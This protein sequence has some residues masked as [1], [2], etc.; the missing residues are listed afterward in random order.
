MIERARSILKSVFG[1]ERFLSL[2]EEVIEHVLRRK[3]CLVVMPTG[4]GKS[5]CYQL[6]ALMFEGLTIVVSPL[7]SLMKDQVE[8][9]REL[10]APVALLNSSLPPQDYRRNV[11][12]I[13]AGRAKLLYAAPETLMKTSLQ[14]LLKKVQ[15]ACLA[16]DE[17]HCISEWGPDFR[18]EYRRLAQVR[19]LMPDSVCMALTATATPRVREDI[20]NCL[21]IDS[22]SEFIA[23]FNRENLFIRVAPKDDPIH[24]TVQFLS[25]FPNES[26]IIYCLTRKQVDDLCSALQ[27]R[28]FQ[29]I[30]YHAGLSEAERHRNQERFVRDQVPIIVATIAFGIGID[31]SNVR[32]ILHYDLPRSIE[33]YYQEIGRAGRDGLPAHCL[34]L[35]SYGDIYKIRAFIDKKE[36]ND[37]RIASLQLN[38]MLQLAEAEVCRRVPLLAYFGEKFPHTGCGMCDNCLAGERELTDVTIP[39]QKFLS[40]V[41]RTGET[42]GTAHIINV[43]LGSKAQKI[44]QH[45][46]DRLSTYG[47]GREY[48]HKQWQ[49][50]ARQLIHKELLD[51]DAQFGSLRLTQQAW[52]VLR[53][54]EHVFARVSDHCETGPVTTG[55]AQPRPAEFDRELFEKLRRK[56]RELADEAKVPPYVVFSDKTL[57]GMAVYLPEDLEQMSQIHGVGHAKLEK[58]GTLFL[59]I[60]AD[61]LR[62][63]PSVRK[64]S[65]PVPPPLERQPNSGRRHILIGEAYNAGQSIPQLAQ[66]FGIQPKTV[67][68][69]LYTCQQEGFPLRPDGFLPLLDLPK[70]LLD[71]ALEAFAELGCGYLRPVFEALREQVSYDDLWVIRLF[72]MSCLRS[73]EVDAARRADA[74]QSNVQLVCLANSRKYA[75]R[76]IAGKQLL[77]GEIGKWIRPVSRREN[78]ELSLEEIALHRD[79]YPNLLDILVIPIQQYCPRSYQS[80]NHHFGV[81]RWQSMGVF[82]G[83]RAALLCDDPE[84]LWINGFHSHGGIN[85]RMPEKLVRDTLSL[86]LLFI[87]PDDLCMSVTPGP[88]GLSKVRAKFKFKGESYCLTVTDPAME[89]TYMPMEVGEYPV[90]RSQAYL[91]VSIGEPFEGF[92]YKLAAAVLLVD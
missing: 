77:A 49:Q 27:R 79:A 20:R 89:A 3:D 2:Q 74:G 37:Q 75:G 26:G 35:L 57:I 76:C 56:R 92:C 68:R 66:Q 61:Y 6:P 43:L 82:P 80:E 34:L 44:L 52:Q 41:K 71:A 54:K 81:G 42:F 23:G 8:Q 22:S 86:S 28:G 45:G 12:M 5:L 88:Q 58:Y 48:S 25:Q 30:P 64:P 83:S 11:E 62:S 17:A 29:A 9:L 10:G 7:I 55:S 73:A 39:A 13:E 21:D 32:F 72:Y 33:S 14:V 40:C 18:P 63:H 15:A 90:A 24:Q 31:K 53:G 78:G 87:R 84:R 59:Q 47:I 70:H 51:Q 38:A 69:H 1:Y 36:G 60:V 50:L 46:H 19:A 65:F 16:I 67:V 4:G 85:D 91:T